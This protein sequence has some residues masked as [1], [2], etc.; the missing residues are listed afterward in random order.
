MSTAVESFKTKLVTLAQ[1]G[2]RQGFTHLYSGGTGLGSYE[3]DQL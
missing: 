2:N 3:L 1:I